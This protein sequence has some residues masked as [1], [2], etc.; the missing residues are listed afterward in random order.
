[1][2]SL[3]LTRQLPHAVEP[4]AAISY[5][6]LASRTDQPWDIHDWATCLADAVLCLVTDRIDAE[7]IE[8][9]SECVKLLANF[10]AGLNHIDLDAAYRR[11]II[12]SNTPGRT[13]R[14]N[15]RRY[16][17]AT[18]GSGSTRWRRGSHDAWLPVAQL[19]SN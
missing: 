7:I 4:R 12:V 9:L 14:L 15:C 16:D 19:G 6:V 11:G 3:A 18:I 10:G 1:M 8:K 2:I 5:K 13:D 17:V